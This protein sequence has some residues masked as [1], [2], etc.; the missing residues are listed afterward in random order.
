MLGWLEYGAGPFPQAGGDEQMYGSCT[1]LT[2]ITWRQAAGEQVATPR[3]QHRD[4]QHKRADGASYFQSVRKAFNNDMS[5]SVEG[6]AVQCVCV[7]S[8]CA[9][10]CVLEAF[11]SL[12]H[13]MTA[14]DCP[15]SSQ[16]LETFCCGFATSSS[17]SI[18]RPMEEW[19]LEAVHAAWGKRCKKKRLKS[20]GCMY[21]PMES[22][23]KEFVLDCL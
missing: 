1:G 21:G 19:N 3:S 2:C 23:T 16:H 4:R 15:D 8:V 17:S 9:C 11:H 22:S 13:L 5:S 20:W 7:V 6:R 14:P 12:F 10:M 18:N